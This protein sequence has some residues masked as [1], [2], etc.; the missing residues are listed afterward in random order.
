MT[1]FRNSGVS[2]IVVLLRRLLTYGAVVV[3]SLMAAACASLP[4][5]SSWGDV[6][7]IGSPAKIL[8]SFSD[9]IV[10]LDPTD[11]KPVKLLDTDGKVRVDDSGNPRTWVLLSPTGTTVHY[12]A[13][14]IQTDDQTLIAGVYED[15]LFQVDAAAARID[16]TEGIVLP[17]HVLGN[18]LLPAAPNDQL[19]YVPLSDNGLVA[20][21]KTDFSQA[22]Q[23]KGDGGKGVWSQPLLVDGT[24]YVSAM[25]HFLFALDAQTGTEKWK[26]ELNG[27]LA[28]TP[29]YAN[30]ALY[31]GSFGHEVYKVGLDGTIAAQYATSDW[32]WGAPTVVDNMVYVTDLGGNVY[33]LK[34][35]G[36]SLDPVWTRKVASAAIRMSPFVSGDTIVVGSRDH[37]VYWIS[38]TTGD[39]INDSGGKPITRAMNGEV[40]SNILLIPTTDANADP[41][42]IVSTIDKS[43]LLVA[44]SLSTGERRWVYS[45]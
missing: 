13:R 6:S 45:S 30:G 34:D 26:V 42:I 11:G 44:F 17:G 14:P 36:S 5:E 37:N 16:K 40:L 1:P 33:A 35:S 27:A 39:A 7:L 2:N 12:Y 10:Q 32:V 22:W 21:K 23:F 15:K 43:E 28:S 19:L 18:P 25:N 24:L 29:T 31:V 38:R 20:L 4:T 3:V 9:R 8:F 41:T